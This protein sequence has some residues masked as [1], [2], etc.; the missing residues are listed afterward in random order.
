MREKEEKKKKKKK[1]KSSVV[2]LWI[3]PLNPGRFNLLQALFAEGCHLFH[4]VS[5]WL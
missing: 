4:L 2:Y 3:I 1:A 5:R